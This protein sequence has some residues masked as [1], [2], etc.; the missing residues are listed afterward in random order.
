MNINLPSQ[1]EQRLSDHATAHGF[2][3]VDEFVTTLLSHVASLSDEATVFAPFDD[4]QQRRSEQLLQRGEEDLASGRFREMRQ[5]LIELGA[6]RGL[7]RD[8]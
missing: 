5:G 2:A 1:E 6:N 8:A 7:H 3:N 4:E